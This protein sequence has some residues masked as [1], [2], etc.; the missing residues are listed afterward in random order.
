[1]FTINHP[2]DVTFKVNVMGSNAE[3]A[4]RLVLGTSPEL[5]FQADRKG[6]AW[7][8]PLRVPTGIEPGVYPLRVEVLLNNRYFVPVKKQV[9]VVSYAG[10]QP[11]AEVVTVATN[12]PPEVVELPAEIPP[13]V[14]TQASVEPTVSAPLTPPPP[15]TLSFTVPKQSS[16]VFQLAAERE[17]PPQV[18]RRPEVAPFV[19]MAPPV[20]AK[21][22]T[23]PA[24]VDFNPPR[25]ELKAISK[26]VENRPKIYP[27]V[28]TPLPKPGAV[29]VKPVQVTLS[30]V[31][32]Q[33]ECMEP[34]AKKPRRAKKEARVMEI[35]QELPVT[36]VKGPIIYE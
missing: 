4:V 16:G 28:E 5:S 19:T 30:D 15:A 17:P 27:R 21:P 31:N 12:A 22:A 36:L 25:P 24:V 3:P 34:T 7:S 13:P 1:M 2:H 11:E 6:D 10:P 14:A 32:R 18:I 23:K 29:Q 33:A 8:A 20:V 26:A 9:E 35:K